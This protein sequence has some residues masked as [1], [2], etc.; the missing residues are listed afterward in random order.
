LTYP[1]GGRYEGAFKNN[2]RDGLGTFTFSD[3]SNYVGAW[4]EDL[5]NG[6][7][8]FTWAEG[9]K[10]SGQ[11]VNGESRQGVLFEQD[12]TQRQIK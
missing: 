2:L 6:K 4:Q 8:I 10:F 12:G 5:K 11:W 1:D 9:S 3:G 7:G